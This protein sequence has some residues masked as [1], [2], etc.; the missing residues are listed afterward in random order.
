VKIPAKFFYASNELFQFVYD[1]RVVGMP[2]STT[3]LL[4]LSNPMCLYDL[5]ALLDGQP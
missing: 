2:I 5:S 4:K 1:K 3:L